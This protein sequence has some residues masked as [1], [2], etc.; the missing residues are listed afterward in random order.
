MTMTAEDSRQLVAAVGSMPSENFRLHM[1][2]RHGVGIGEENFTFDVEQPYRA[3]HRRQHK[4]LPGLT[5]RHSPESPEAE[6]EFALECMRENRLRGWRQ[7]AGAKGVVCFC[8]DG[9]FGIRLK[10]ETRYYNQVDRV[11]RILM[12]GR[13]IK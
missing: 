7:I 13:F 2:H 12:K 8:D 1:I 10:E 5:H 6:M 11:A 3:L 9:S 4:L